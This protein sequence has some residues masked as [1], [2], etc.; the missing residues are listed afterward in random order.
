MKYIFAVAYS[1]A[2]CLFN[3]I[4]LTP[5]TSTDFY[6]FVFDLWTHLPISKFVPS[7]NFQLSLGR[8]LCPHWMTV[9]QSYSS[10]VSFV[11][12][13]CGVIQPMWMTDCCDRAGVWGER[14][15]ELPL[16]SHRPKSSPHVASLSKLK[17]I[18]ESCCKVEKR[19]YVIVVN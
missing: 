15:F 1:N 8:H 16:F 14:F 19:G 7:M 6:Y 4:W 12:C 13:V 10:K 11:R 9:N 3:H 5:K 18:T 17:E 2:K